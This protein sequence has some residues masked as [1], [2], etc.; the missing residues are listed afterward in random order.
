[1]DFNSRSRG[2]WF[3]ESV[4][5]RSLIFSAASAI[6]RNKNTVN[7]RRSFRANAPLR[8]SAIHLHK[9]TSRLKISKRRS[10]AIAA[11]PSNNIALHNNMVLHSRMPRL[12]GPLISLSHSQGFVS[13]PFLPRAAPLRSS[14][15]GLYPIQCH[16]HRITQLPFPAVQVRSC[17]CRTVTRIR[18]RFLRGC[19]GAF[20]SGS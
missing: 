5:A 14:S 13:V 16:P 20:L 15:N 17:I 2:N 18:F 6:F 3:A 7:S 11:H 12:S 19:Q 10:S 1:M 4:S 9:L 8:I